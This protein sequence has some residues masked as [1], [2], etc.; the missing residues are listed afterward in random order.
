M[1]RCTL[2]A[3]HDRAGGLSAHAGHNA[4]GT[5]ARDAGGGHSIGHRNRSFHLRAHYPGSY[6]SAHRAGDESSNCVGNN[7]SGRY[8]DANS[9]P[10]SNGHQHANVDPHGHQDGGHCLPVACAL[11]DDR[12][13]GGA[14][15]APGHRHAECDS[16][17]DCDG[18]SYPDGWAAL[19]D[20]N[21]NAV[22]NTQHNA[23]CYGHAERHLD[24]HA[25]C[26]TADLDA[27]LDSHLDCDAEPDPNG[28][29]PTL[30]DPHGYAIRDANGR[31]ICHTP[32]HA[33]GHSRA[34]CHFN[35]DP[36]GDPD[37]HTAPHQHG[38][39]DRNADGNAVCH[40]H[41]DAHGDPDGHAHRNPD[42]YRYGDPDARPDP[43][44]G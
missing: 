43:R 25:Y 36:I 16:H 29:S 26:H 21:R 10:V 6:R 27:D 5:N 22:S 20:G 44:I 37:G 4:A 11:R 30:C 34:I 8:G 13:V 1:P 9:S 39:F 31:A 23:D 3:D 19:S 14:S 17:T 15:G 33:H 32:A 28:H 24:Q 12:N 40:T 2:G 18:E 38:D 7:G 42:G 35:P 41:R